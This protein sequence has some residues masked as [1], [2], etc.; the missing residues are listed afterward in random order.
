MSSTSLAWITPPI[1]GLID[2]MGSLAGVT[3]RSMAST[4][5]DM[6]WD[7][8]VR[9]GAEVFWAQTCLSELPDEKIAI[10]VGER[11]AAELAYRLLMLP[12]APVEITEDIEMAY[13]EI[14]NVAIGAWNGAVKVQQLQWDNSVE[15]RSLRRLSP[16][17]EAASLAPHGW[18]FVGV[19]VFLDDQMHQIAIGTT[20]QW[21]PEEA[22]VVIPEVLIRYSPGARVAKQATGIAA[23]EPVV[24]ASPVLR[25]EPSQDEDAPP[26]TSPRATAA[27]AMERPPLALVTPPEPVAEEP[28][29]A[30]PVV[31]EP[32]APTPIIKRAPAPVDEAPPQREAPTP[33]PVAPAPVAPHAASPGVSRGGL[34]DGGP[35]VS[36]DSLLL[37]LAEYF[38]AVG[39]VTRTEIR[40]TMRPRPPLG[41]S[42]LER[43]GV[44]T[45]WTRMPMPGRQN[46][47]VAIV[48]GEQLAE[49]LA[50]RMLAGPWGASADPTIET[51]LREIAARGGRAWNEAVEHEAMQWDAAPESIRVASVDQIAEAAELRAEGLGA[52]GASLVINGSVHH[53]ALAGTGGWLP[54]DAR[55]TASGGGVLAPQADTDRPMVRRSDPKNEPSG[56]LDRSARRTAEWEL[57]SQDEPGEDGMVVDGHQPHL[58]MVDMSGALLAW[59]RQQLLNPRNRFAWGTDEALRAGK[60]RAAVLVDPEA[61][62]AAAIS[63]THRIVLRRS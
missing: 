38:A 7:S 45:W 63:A 20:G 50:A 48:M 25:V 32:P 43:C 46:G 58:L 33:V 4:K 14:I 35:S 28:A 52:V 49:D 9:C 29:P 62:E 36:W 31:T 15:A 24:A 39:F 23:P 47:S 34:D 57:R 26:P 21:L 8:V 1:D 42:A 40:L 54:S 6:G 53:I 55:L 44:Q 19:S 10:V 18:H 12:E 16:L 17:S 22:T 30:A 59:V 60:Y 3:L 5:L 56:P 41:W 37:P 27:S 13:E 11:F 61:L 51:A 2:S